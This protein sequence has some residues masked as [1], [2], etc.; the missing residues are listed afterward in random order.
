[1]IRMPRG[2]CETC[3]IVKDDISKC[4]K[5]H[6]E[7]EIES[8]ETFAIR[9]ATVKEETPIITFDYTKALTNLC[10]IHNKRAIG[11][12][13]DCKR[14][15]CGADHHHFDH[16]SFH[17]VECGIDNDFEPDEMEFKQ[18]EYLLSQLTELWKH[19]DEMFELALKVKFEVIRN[20]SIR[21][22]SLSP[23]IQKYT[24]QALSVVNSLKKRSIEHD[25]ERIAADIETTKTDILNLALSD[26]VKRVIE[27]I[28]T[29][30]T[31]VTLQEKYRIPLTVRYNTL[32]DHRMITVGS[33]YVV[34]F[35]SKTT[36]Y[37]LFSFE[38]DHFI[39]KIVS[40]KH[41]PLI[42]NKN[43][44]LMRANDT[45]VINGVESKNKMKNIEFNN[46]IDYKIYFLNTDDK[47][48][49]LNIETM[50]EEILFPEFSFKSI[51]TLYRTDIEAICQDSD[52]YIYYIKD[53][54]IHK[55]EWKMDF[56]DIKYY[57]G[58][59]YNNDINYGILAS[60]RMIY[61]QRAPS[62]KIRANF[63][64]FDKNVLICKKIRFH[65]MYL[66]F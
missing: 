53:S 61:K 22:P 44:L 29:V 27:D 4:I 37:D 6:H 59:K 48:V 19:K 56:D 21:I 25:I 15:F 66:I 9:Y 63:I 17:F 62:I 51:L 54:G 50:N 10:P 57:V 26:N 41:I 24:I 30:R 32:N 36:L 47:L 13:F 64:Y 20:V 35:N 5:R 7:F 45:I 1:M 12:C 58:S 16:R 2:Y 65:E 31:C 11:F 40:D 38:R 60:N 23:T 8:D 33:N 34:L 39:T 28:E 52:G 49:K 46:N 14:C 42:I 43:R 3:K 55:Y 18:Y